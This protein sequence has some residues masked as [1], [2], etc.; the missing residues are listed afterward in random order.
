MDLA[1]NKKKDVEDYQNCIL[2][3]TNLLHVSYS[4]VDYYKSQNPVLSN[5]GLKYALF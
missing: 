1:S 5:C 3:I 2:I 4:C